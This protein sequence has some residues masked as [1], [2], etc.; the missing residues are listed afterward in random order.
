MEL[1]VNDIAQFKDLV[2]SRSH[3]SFPAS[4]ESQLR[5]WITQRALAGGY[6]SFD[7]YFRTLHASHAEFER[8]I[9]LITTRE[10]Y[11]FRMPEQFE[12]LGRVVLPAIVDREGKKAMKALSWKKPYRMQLRAWSAGCAMGQEAYSLSMQILDAIRYPKAWDIRV[13]GTDINAE[14]LEIARAARYDSTRLGKT[15]SPFIERYFQVSGLEE[16][17]VAGAVRDITT[18]Q[19]VNLR[20]L[21]DLASLKNAFD[22]IFCRNVM[23]YFDLPAQQRLI[24]AL[25]ECLKPGG[26]LFTGEGEVLHLYDHAFTVKELGACIFYQKSEECAYV[27]KN[28]LAEGQSGGTPTTAKS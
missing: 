23:I 15:P 26:Y 8:L 11:F 6:R 25:W 1:T 14:A 7:E 22:I 10:T 24:S 28:D 2:Y 3:L 5:R 12:A 13:L 16:I 27:V 20:N 18:F 21:P 4:R 17:T 9:A 19:A